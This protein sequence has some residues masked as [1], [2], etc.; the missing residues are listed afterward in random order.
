M[1]QSLI[2]PTLLARELNSQISSQV[3]SCMLWRSGEV[4][5]CPTQGSPS[6][7]IY[8]RMRGGATVKITPLIDELSGLIRRTEGYDRL[9]ID[10]NVKKMGCDDEADMVIELIQAEMDLVCLLDTEY[11]NAYFDQDAVY[12]RWTLWRS[13]D[14]IISTI[15]VLESGVMH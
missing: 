6:Y 14:Q 3:E 4:L 10:Y 13:L 9:D 7:P 15:K 2:T 11:Y 12:K 5:F 1:G 8:Q